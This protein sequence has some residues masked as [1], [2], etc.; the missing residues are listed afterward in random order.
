MQLGN[1]MV[2]RELL[3]N[4]RFGVAGKEQNENSEVLSI[5]HVRGAARREKEEKLETGQG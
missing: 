5:T 1:Q 3:E 2:S 4:E